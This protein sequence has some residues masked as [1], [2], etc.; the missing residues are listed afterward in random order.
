MNPHRVKTFVINHKNDAVDAKAC[1]SAALRED[2]RSIPIK[3]K[4]Q[5]QL[6]FLHRNRS[7]NIQSRTQ[8][9]N[10]LRAIF[11][12]LG[13]EVPQGKCRILAVLR[14]TLLPE[15]PMQLIPELLS[16]LRDQFEILEKLEESIRRQ[17]ASLRAWAKRDER[18]QKLMTIPGVSFITSTAI[19][20]K[21]GNGFDFKKGREF[22][23]FLGLTPKQNSSGARTRLGG[24]T[25]HGDRYIRC[26]LVHGGRACV[27]AA[28][29]LEPETGEYRHQDA[30]HRWIRSV[31]ERCGFN[32]AAVA[33]ANKNARMMIG[34]LKGEDE[35]RW[36]LAHREI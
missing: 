29:G 20:A 31:R 1:A 6:Q 16:D 5:T 21:I 26:L 18:A 34:I 4:E 28:F 25:K 12:E 7:Q 15:N 33:V 9:L 19:I 17:D 13:I 36:E 30:H 24:I 35:Y 14:Q 8:C 11:A 27:A 2:V 3:T 22:S 23:A 32:K 10:L